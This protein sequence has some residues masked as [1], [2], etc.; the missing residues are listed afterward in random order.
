MK[1]SYRWSLLGL[2]ALFGCADRTGPTSP[3]ME[4]AVFAALGGLQ[5]GEALTFTGAEAAEVLIAA[6][7]TPGEFVY[8]PFH[9]TDVGEAFLNLTIRGEG[10]AT[11]PS[12][13]AMPARH[14]HSPAR[15]DVARWEMHER[16]HARMQAEA[17][18]HLRELPR[19]SRE[20]APQ[21]RTDLS[22]D[23]ARV[24]QVVAINADALGPFCRGIDVR[25]GRV[26]AIGQRIIV[27]ADLGNPEG[28]LTRADYQAFAQRF[29]Q[30]VDP[31]VTSFF[32]QPTDIDNN[33][34]VIAF[35][36]RAVNELT[37]PGDEGFIGGFFWARDLLLRQQQ[38]CPASNQG[39][40]FFML[41]A[42]PR[43][44]ASP[45]A[46]PRERVFQLAVS[47]LGHEYQHLINAGRRIWVNDAPLEQAW[48]DEALSHSAEELLFYADTGAQPRQNLDLGTLQARGWTRAFDQ[49]QRSNVGRYRLYVQN[50][51]AESPISP[52]DR[53]HTRGAAWSF[54]RYVVDHL[55]RPEEQFF[56]ALVDS[57]LTGYANL[58]NV[59]GEPPMDWLQ[60]WGVSIYTDDLPGLATADPLLTQPSWN[61]RDLMT[62][63]Y[64][65]YPLQV[66]RLAAN[67]QVP[68]SIRGGS[69]AFVEVRGEPGL[70]GRVLTTSGGAPPPA[71]LRATLVRV[72]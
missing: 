51:A 45:I 23:R 6:G 68:L 41:A 14:A 2:L 25:Q 58:R 50:V 62:R 54:L 63:I 4:Q 20:I 46:H 42:D 36:T 8:V 13:V 47:T 60:R 15:E 44:E 1:V 53:L 11:A 43:A 55:E 48:L 52:I 66:Q 72:N 49:F 12:A 27:V 37:G 32:G 26:E 29:D 34:R 69:S 21:I 67:Q 3:L 33:G 18:A 7:R 65:S 5:A 22:G 31:T 70:P 56:P 59:M 24:D 9:A 10:L 19:F 61:M 71:Q 30:L 64:G 40:I 57:R 28:G 17:A 16:M 38:N 35:F 39:E